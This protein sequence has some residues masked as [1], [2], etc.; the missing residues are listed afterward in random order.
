MVWLASA[1]LVVRVCPFLSELGVTNYAD[2][3]VPTIFEGVT[4]VERFRCQLP[5]RGEDLVLILHDTKIEPRVD[6]KMDALFN[7]RTLRPRTV[8][9]R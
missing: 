4:L 8:C 3:E 1:D 5:G 2:R 9:K 7:D 6:K